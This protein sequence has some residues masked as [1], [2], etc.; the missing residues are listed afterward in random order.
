MQPEKKKRSVFDDVEE[1]NGL[2]EDINQI[3]DDFDF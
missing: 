2:A 3:F 1:L